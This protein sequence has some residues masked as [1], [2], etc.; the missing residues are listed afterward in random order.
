MARK[1]SILVVTHLKIEFDFSP[2]LDEVDLFSSG[3][4]LIDSW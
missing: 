3:L 1:Y 4:G 2:S